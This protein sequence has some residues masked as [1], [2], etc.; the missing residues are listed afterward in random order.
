MN[1]FF[2]N[3]VVSFTQN[4]NYVHRKKGGLKELFYDKIYY[5]EIN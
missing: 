2:T 1:E 4:I 3:Q 5:W